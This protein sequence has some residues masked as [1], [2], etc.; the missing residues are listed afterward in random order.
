MEVFICA[1]LS[2]FIA[3]LCL[4]ILVQIILNRTR[5][6]SIYF[7]TSRPQDNLTRFKSYSPNRVLKGLLWNRPKGWFTHQGNS[8]F[9]QAPPPPNTPATES[10]RTLQEI[11][12]CSG[13]C[14]MCSI[15]LQGVLSR[16]PFYSCTIKRVLFQQSGPSSSQA[17]WI[18]SLPLAANVMGS[19]RASL[20]ACALAQLHVPTR[21]NIPTVRPP[22]CHHSYLHWEAVSCCIVY[23]LA[24]L[25]EAVLLWA[26]SGIKYRVVL[27]YWGNNPEF[28]KWNR[29]VIP[30]LTVAI[31]PFLHARLP[32]SP[33]H[34]HLGSC[35]ILYDPR[36]WRLGEPG[37]WGHWRH[38]VAPFWVCHTA[39]WHHSAWSAGQLE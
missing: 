3:S 22:F 5:S 12:W 4:K 38:P 1:N 35:R 24:F 2:L 31:V 16:Y 34:H 30:K 14:D 17:K 15:M 10:I 11:S 27:A 6:H 20:L 7:S 33:E 8:T 23:V 36:L 9:N 19:W 21:A 39:L 18:D 28:C 26:D 29:P 37:R 25:T 13:I 32:G